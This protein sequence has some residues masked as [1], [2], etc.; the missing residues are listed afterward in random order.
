MAV[1]RAVMVITNKG[2]KEH[3]TLAAAAEACR[4]SPFVLKKRLE[5]G[6]EVDG[7][8]VRWADAAPAAAAPRDKIAKMAAPAVTL[9]PPAAIRTDTLASILAQIAAAAAGAGIVIEG[10]SIGEMKIERIRIGA[11]AEVANG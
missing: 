9:Q 10:I 4:V 6:E 3:P 2:E 8:R 7:V 5:A 11:A 1:R